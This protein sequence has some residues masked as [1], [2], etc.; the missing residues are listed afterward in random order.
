MARL[1]R[2]MLQ[3]TMAHHNVSSST[4]PLL[5]PDTQ[6]KTDIEYTRFAK[7]AGD[8]KVNPCCVAKAA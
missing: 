8:V 6:P 7:C 4:H 5:L 2:Y 3:C 1:L